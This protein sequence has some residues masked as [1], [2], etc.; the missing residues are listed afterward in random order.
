MAGGTNPPY[1][2]GARLLAWLAPQSGSP[3]V[4]A[5]AAQYAGEPGAVENGIAE[6]L[7]WDAINLKN[8][9]ARFPIL[10]T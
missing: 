7:P 3:L 5:P 2:I 1:S 8:M 6:H 10:T 4:E 9:L